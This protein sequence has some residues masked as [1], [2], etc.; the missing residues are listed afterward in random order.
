MKKGDA[1]YEL[2]KKKMKKIILSYLKKV[3]VE[4][5]DYHLVF[6]HSAE[7]WREL[8]RAGLIRPGMTYDGFLSNLTTEG[9]KALM[10]GMI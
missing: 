5:A 3:G 7:L 4:P 2:L 6:Q 10:R 1:D 9:I 8:G